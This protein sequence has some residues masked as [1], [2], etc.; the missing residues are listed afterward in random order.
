MSV[1]CSAYCQVRCRQVFHACHVSLFLSSAETSN[2]AE[3]SVNI[4]AMCSD[5]DAAVRWTVKEDAYFDIF[6]IVYECFDENGTLVHTSLDS[7]SCFEPYPNWAQSH[8]G[9]SGVGKQLRTGLTC[10]FKAGYRV[11]AQTL[12]K[13][14]N[15][16]VKSKQVIKY[17]YSVCSSIVSTGPVVCAETPDE[18]NI[19]RVS[20]INEEGECEVECAA[21]F[22]GPLCNSEYIVSVQE[23]A[24]N[25][26]NVFRHQRM[27]QHQHMW[28]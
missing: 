7:D 14:T 28:R 21:G 16:T 15:C 6:L 11:N 17:R 25:V 20:E 8:T 27:Q 9:T 23:S 2:A 13:V 19:D 18:C 3:D 22:A 24:S 4:C 10:Q 26:S 1:D 12:Y 5:T